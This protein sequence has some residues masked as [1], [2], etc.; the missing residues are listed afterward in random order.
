MPRL[1]PTM[2]LEDQIER[3]RE[4]RLREG[5]RRLSILIWAIL[6]APWLVYANV[7]IREPSDLYLYASVAMP[8]LLICVA[9][10][11]A[12]RLQ[13]RADRCRRPRA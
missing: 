1:P 2:W 8:V 7:V 11:L 4:R 9:H 3:D 12:L 6:L 10:H 5:Y 13:R